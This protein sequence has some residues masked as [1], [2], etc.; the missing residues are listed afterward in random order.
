MGLSALAHVFRLTIVVHPGQRGRGV[1]TALM[2]SALGWAEDDQR[3][4]K[5]ELLVR[6]TNHNAIRLYR[7]LGF[8]EEGRLREHVRLPSG[9]FVDDIA[10][11]WFPKR[12]GT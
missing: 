1:G 11:A 7:K 10:M 6:A 4:R 2:R 8:L 12:L 3:V 9:R 5:I